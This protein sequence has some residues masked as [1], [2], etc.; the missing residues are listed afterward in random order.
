MSTSRRAWAFCSS[1]SSPGAPK[2]FPWGRLYPLGDHLPAK[3][4]DEVT[5]S[6]GASNR[7][8]EVINDTG[9]DR[10]ASAGAWLA[11]FESTGIYD[12][13]RVVQRK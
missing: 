1:A 3:V 12:S 2:P 11:C 8:G 7:D 5:S 4:L 13:Y 9:T 6:L 10:S